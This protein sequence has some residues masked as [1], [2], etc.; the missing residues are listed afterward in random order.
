MIVKLK[1]KHQ[2]IQ[3][4]QMMGLIYE[5]IADSSQDLETLRVC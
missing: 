5:I 1:S 4:S 3:T 2:V